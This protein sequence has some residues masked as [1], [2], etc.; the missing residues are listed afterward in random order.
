LCILLADSGLMEVVAMADHV[1]LRFA[2]RF[3]YA[4]LRL[5]TLMHVS[6]ALA[7][8]ILDLPMCCDCVSLGCDDPLTMLCGR[9]KWKDG[10]YE[11]MWAEIGREMID[12]DGIV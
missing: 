8:P 2:T 12:E 6:L 9:G 1:S 7:L 11:Y 10:K 5:A 4:W 3:I